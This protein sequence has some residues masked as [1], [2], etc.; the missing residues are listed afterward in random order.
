M[1]EPLA[2]TSMQGAV[3]FHP[4][5]VKK[6]DHQRRDLLGVLER[7]FDAAGAAFPLLPENRTLLTAEAP[8][9]DSQRLLFAGAVTASHLENAYRAR[10]SFNGLNAAE[11]QP[12]LSEAAAADPE[13]EKSPPTVLVEE[14]DREVGA[15]HPGAHVSEERL[16]GVAERGEQVLRRQRGHVESVCLRA[17]QLGDQV[18]IPQPHQQSWS[19]DSEVLAILMN[20]LSCHC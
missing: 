11:S 14:L 4:P 15:V 1:V 8:P 19:A 2:E 18:S 7:V 12:Y 5:T 9:T 3:L 16:G 20:P 6:R 17:E 10:E 13:D